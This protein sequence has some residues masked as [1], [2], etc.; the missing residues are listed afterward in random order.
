MEK[1]NKSIEKAIDYEILDISQ[2]D[3]KVLSTIVS[4]KED[5]Q[6]NI[7]IDVSILVPILS[8]G[9][10]KIILIYREYNPLHLKHCMV[11]S[12]EILSNDLYIKEFDDFEYIISF[13]LPIINSLYQ[14]KEEDIKVEIFYDENEYN[15]KYRKFIVSYDKIKNS[16]YKI[17][18]LYKNK[19]KKVDEII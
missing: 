12:S 1:N 5:I 10:I 6:E 16:I 19:E 4:N 2:T 13:Y 9:E 3:Y 18:D 15:I 8:N 17:Q 14:E 7:Y 11:N